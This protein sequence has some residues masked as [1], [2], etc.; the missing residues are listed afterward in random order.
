MKDGDPIPHDQHFVRYA[1]PDLVDRGTGEVSERLFMHKE[2]KP[3]KQPKDLSANWLEAFEAPIENQLGEIRKRVGQGL[4]LKENGRFAECNVGYVVETTSRVMAGVAVVWKPI[5]GE[6]E[7]PSHVDIAG[8]PNWDH[9]NSRL[10]GELI[11]SCVTR[12][13]RARVDDHG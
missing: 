2:P 13:H 1:S 12:T 7:D 10:V 11:A 5:N 3:S 4:N 9:R 8:L 6:D